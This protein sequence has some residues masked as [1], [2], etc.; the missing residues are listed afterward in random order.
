[1]NIK[2]F[3]QF[4]SENLSMNESTDWAEIR[5]QI[6]S[7]RGK[8]TDEIGEIL[9]GF[10]LDNYEGDEEFAYFDLMSPVDNKNI[11][12]VVAKITV[13]YGKVTTVNSMDDEEIKDYL[14]N[15]K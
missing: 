2:K 8:E 10:E 11:T 15:K 13:E 4:I 5:R 14:A 7:L 12:H 9:P 3:G 1:M 6:L